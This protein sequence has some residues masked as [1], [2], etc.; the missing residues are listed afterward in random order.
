MPEKIFSIIVATKDDSAR[1][2]YLLD[3]LSVQAF[4][5]F[6]LIVK[7]SGRD[8]AMLEVL[9]HYEQA[10]AIKYID[11]F[12][13]GIYEAWNRA[14]SESTGEYIIFLGA[15][16]WPA[17]NE[18]LAGY[19]N[20]IQDNPG[21]LVYYNRISVFH[22]GKRKFELRPE[23]WAIERRRFLEELKFGHTGVA[24][25]RKA[26]ELCGQ[27]NPAYSV[28]GDYDHLLRVYNVDQDSFFYTDSEFF[29]M[30]YGGIST[31]VSGRVFAYRES[32]KALF[33][34]RKKLSLV[35]LV[36]YLKAK[37]ISMLRSS[38]L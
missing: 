25:N 34:Q 9:G 24:I 15:D 5:G 11:D 22:D 3:K 19:Y 18:S 12:D 13:Q 4:K 17:T 38:P 26:F 2:S 23:D 1:I 27:F 35:L 31:S 29:C 21:Y 30:A 8:Q 33:I 6:E 32:L 7:N 37:L 10:C 28:S 16:D 36:R 14:L 20:K